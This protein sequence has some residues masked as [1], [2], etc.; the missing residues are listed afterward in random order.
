[1]YEGRQL[2]EKRITQKVVEYNIEYSEGDIVGFNEIIDQ[3]IHK[4]R[5]DSI[6]AAEDSFIIFISKSQFTWIFS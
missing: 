3:P 6:I 5:V 2:W 4:T 1:M